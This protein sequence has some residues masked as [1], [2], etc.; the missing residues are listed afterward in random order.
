MS[1]GVPALTKVPG[2]RVEAYPNVAPDPNMY[3]PRVLI[4]PFGPA[5]YRIILNPPVPDLSF[6][7]PKL[8]FP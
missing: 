2:S 8:C 3:C 6:L 4:G 1:A 7:D 5:P